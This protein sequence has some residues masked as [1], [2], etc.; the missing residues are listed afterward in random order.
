MKSKEAEYLDD[1]PPAQFALIDIDKANGG[2]EQEV[3]Q[4]R[5]RIHIQLEFTMQ[6]GP[7]PYKEKN[8]YNDIQYDQKQDTHLTSSPFLRQI[9]DDLHLPSI[10][11]PG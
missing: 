3:I 5:Q 8:R 10:I 6:N 4:F 9:P 7:R 1:H 11:M 2:H